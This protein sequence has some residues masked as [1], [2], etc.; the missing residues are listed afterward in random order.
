MLKRI[1]IL[2]FL[3]GAIIANAQ[4]TTPEMADTFRQE[5]K[6]YVVIGV[7]SIVFTCIVLM[8]LWLERK[9]SKLEKEVKESKN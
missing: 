2:L 7:L 4:E 3:F 8:L 1:Y 6:I 9:L 5:G